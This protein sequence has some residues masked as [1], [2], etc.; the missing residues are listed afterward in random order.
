MMPTAAQWLREHGPQTLLR[1]QNL[2]ALGF[3]AVAL[4]YCI[5]IWL[6]RDWIFEAVLHRDFAHRDTILLL[7]CGVFLLMVC[8]DLLCQLLIARARFK[9]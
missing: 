1:R 2:F 7:W 6:L 4:C 8:R 5:V 9:Q 3:T